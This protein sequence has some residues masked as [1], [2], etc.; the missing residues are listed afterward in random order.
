MAES[1]KMEEQNTR[2]IICDTKNAEMELSGPYFIFYTFLDLI[3]FAAMW[4][5]FDQFYFSTGKKF[6][7]RGR[8]GP[9]IRS[10]HMSRSIL[11]EL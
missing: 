9:V 6:K 1:E 7:W 4:Q 10:V 3:F 2:Q 5:F 11:D 8:K